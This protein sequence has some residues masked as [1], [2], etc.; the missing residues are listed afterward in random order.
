MA[1][2]GFLL[3]Q[4]YCIGCQG[5]Q[6]ACQQRNA[7]IPGEFLRTADNFEKSDKKEFIT[8][9]CFHCEIPACANV[10]PVSA[11]TKDSD[12]GIVWTDYETCIGCKACIKAC[13]YNAPVYNEEKNVSHKCDLCRDRIAQGAKPACVDAC[14]VKVLS[15][16]TM[17]EI[18]TPETTKY[19]AGFVYEDTKPSARFIVR[20]RK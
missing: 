7:S 19:G 12:T 14:P 2:L 8:Q 10:C 13:P 16:G 4:R 9:S 11:I 5:C 20:K 3:D 6:S 18:S 1:Q 17:E 15:V